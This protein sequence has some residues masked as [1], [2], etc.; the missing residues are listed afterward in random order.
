MR[1]SLFLVAVL[2]ASGACME[3]VCGCSPLGRGTAVI[4]GTVTDPSVAPVEHA[5]V[6]FKLLFE[7]TC[8]GTGP[9][10]G[11][12]QSTASGRFRHTASWAGGTKAFCLWA[13]P[14]VG[15]TWATSDSQVVHVNYN[16]LSGAVPDSVELAFQLRP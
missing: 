8:A 2:L 14:P 3:P 11:W 9:I 7:G 16:G 13:E 15:R 10:T 4:T 5:R 12:V 1:R 6:M